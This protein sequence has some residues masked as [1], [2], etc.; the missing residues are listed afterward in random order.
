M[1]RGLSSRGLPVAITPAMVRRQGFEPRPRH[2][3][4]ACRS[5]I[6]LAA[7]EPYRGVEPRY[8]AWKANVFPLDQY[9]VVGPA[10]IEPAYA[11]FR[12]AAKSVSAR[13]PWSGSEDSN[14][15]C[16][17]PGQARLPLRYIPSRRNPRSRT[18]FLL[19]PNQADCRLPR[20][21]EVLRRPGARLAL[22]FTPA[23][24][25]G[26][27]ARSTV[28]MAGIEPAATTLAGRV[29]YLSC[30]PLGRYGARYS[31]SPVVA[32]LSFAASPRSAGMAGLPIMV[33]TLL[34]C[35]QASTFTR[36][37]CSVGTAGVEPAFRS[38]WS[39]AA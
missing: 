38:G 12:P 35:Q 23:F 26:S 4:R 39:R 29:R 33:L 13:D 9:G 21:R 28:E 20:S 34:M 1:P 10:G 24:V 18:A 6:E 5:T 11:G 22:A 17:L 19:I 25:P 16:L 37:W 31:Q 36:R 30:H 7:R 27:R 32:G 2:R 15:V 3:L 8:F 14:L